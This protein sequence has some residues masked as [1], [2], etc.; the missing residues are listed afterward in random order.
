MGTHVTACT[1]PLE[2]GIELGQGL[3]IVSVL[4]HRHARHVHA[5]RVHVRLR[6]VQEVQQVTKVP[7]KAEILANLHKAAAF[8]VRGD[9]PHSQPQR[10]YNRRQQK[11][12]K[13][14]RQKGMTCQR[15]SPKN[16]VKEKHQR[17][18]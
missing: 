2:Y 14:T 17:C 13:L 4:G 1:A 16:R 15:K 11:N 8:P 7:A 10:Q 18:S 6:L 5:R 3:D 9:E 12:R